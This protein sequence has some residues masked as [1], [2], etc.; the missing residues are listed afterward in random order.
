MPIV[1]ADFSRLLALLVIDFDSPRIAGHFFQLSEGCTIVVGFHSA[2]GKD[3]AVIVELSKL[4][5]VQ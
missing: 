4:V 2:L 1:H 3:L 5:G